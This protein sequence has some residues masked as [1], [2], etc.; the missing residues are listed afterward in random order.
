MEEKI[1]QLIDRC[2]AAYE[3]EQDDAYLSN[4]YHAKLEEL[5][6]L[7]QRFAEMGATELLDSLRREQ[8]ALEARLR[9]EEEHPTFYWYDEHHHAKQLTGILDAR[10]SVMELLE[11]A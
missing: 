4:V 2:E 10:R 8:P 5:Q 11:G 9:E 6:S 1:Q 7:R 3:K